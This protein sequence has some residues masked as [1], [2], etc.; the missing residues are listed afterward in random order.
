[1]RL[2]STISGSFHHK[3]DKNVDL[4]NHRTWQTFRCPVDMSGRSGGACVLRAVGLTVHG[5]TVFDGFILCAPC[6]GQ[7]HVT[8]M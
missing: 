1:M 6:D 8:P 2:C 5:I 3:I 4:G 7:V